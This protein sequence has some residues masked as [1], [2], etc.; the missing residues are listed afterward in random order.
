VSS[1][2]TVQ[3]SGGS[4]LGEG[5]VTSNPGPELAFELLGV[6]CQDIDDPKKYSIRI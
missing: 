2:C 5:G 4:G 3:P 1:V 6:K